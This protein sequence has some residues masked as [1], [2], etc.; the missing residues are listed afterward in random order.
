MSRREHI[1]HIAKKYRARYELFSQPGTSPYATDFGGVEGWWVPAGVNW[2]TGID[3]AEPT[4]I[5]LGFAEDK[6]S[7]YFTALH[8]LGH[9][10]LGHPNGYFGM[11][12]AEIMRAEAQAW[13]W[14]FAHASE[15]PE[16]STRRFIRDSIKSYVDFHGQ[17]APIPAEVTG[18]FAIVGDDKA[19]AA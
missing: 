11:P 18:V 19:G 1:D 5:V 6:Q 4:S 9:Q 3:F 2:I 14:A 8:E 15:E 16:G 12:D 10:V 7:A 17:R 13:L